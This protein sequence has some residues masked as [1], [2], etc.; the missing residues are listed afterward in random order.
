MHDELQAL[1]RHAR[2]LHGILGW[3]AVTSFGLLGVLVSAIAVSWPESV[4]AVGAVGL[5]AWLLS[6]ACGRA[7]GGQVLRARYGGPIALQAGPALL[8]LA[9]I[10]LLRMPE[11]D[12]SVSIAIG[13]LAFGIAA[14]GDAA[15]AQQ[16]PS[17]PRRC[18]RVRAA[19]G[20]VAA[21]ALAAAPVT[22]LIIA[23]AVAGASELYLAVRLLPEVER[24]TQM[25]ERDGAASEPLL[26]PLLAQPAAEEEL[27]PEPRFEAGAS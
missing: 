6:T 2:P 11:A 12:P 1:G 16:F 26:L 27:Q 23:A 18:L 24:L 19:G 14:A 13:G 20:V 21:I 7:G 8:A 4:R 9:G 10:V 3:W 25:V 15:A 17:L 22:G 5:G